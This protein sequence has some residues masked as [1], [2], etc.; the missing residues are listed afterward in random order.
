MDALIYW[1]A[2]ALVAVIQA[3][4]LR[5]VAR[6]G[7]G[8]GRLAFYL[9]ARYRRVTLQNLTLCFG[10][11]KSPAEIRELARKNFRR[12]GENYLCAIKTAAMTAGEECRSR[13]SPYH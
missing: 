8:L 9:T 10:H 6:L 11:E 3:L 7:R 5:F 2:R 13:W 1:P 4:P 12:L